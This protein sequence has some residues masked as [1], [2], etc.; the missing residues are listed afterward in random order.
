[1]SIQPENIK[2]SIVKDP[3]Y[4]YV[5]VGFLVIASVAIIMVLWSMQGNSPVNAPRTLTV[6]SFSA[7]ETVMEK[8]IFPAFQAKWLR[9]HGER[10]EFITT[11]AGSGVITRQIMT[12]F[13]AEIAILS[14][15]LDARRLVGAGILNTASWMAL[16]QK[17]K[18]CRT[19]IV[20]FFRDS[21]SSVSSDL[22]DLDPS[23]LHIVIP[24]PLV[25]G[26]GQL[27][28][29]AMYGSR[30]RNGASHEQ[31]L[32]QVLAQ[33][34]GLRRFPSNARD[35]MD[36]FQAGLG[37]VLLNYEVAEYFHPQGSKLRAILPKRTLLAE[38][39]AVSIDRNVVGRQQDLVN[40]FLD[41]LWQ[42]EAQRLL[43][44]YGFRTL[45]TAAQPGFAPA[46]DHDVFSLG[47]MGSVLEVNKQVILPLLKSLE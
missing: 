22:D 37:D 41:Y 19:P 15:E 24:D 17:P 4:R 25:S 30:R 21:L 8:A 35:A 42:P 47:D 1:M 29:L 3:A 6:Y 7:M 46:S 10:V 33:F 9:E 20:M 26:E 23:Q 11:F 28:A 2:P 12:H 38:P 36:Q 5:T 45:N 39:V 40:D 27:A 16:T 14:S 13:P 32:D 43:S 31:A 44:E 18:F 34:S